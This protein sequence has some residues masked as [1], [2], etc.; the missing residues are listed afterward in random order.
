MKKILF[1][2]MATLS[3]AMQAQTTSDLSFV[4]NPV[5]VSI[6]EGKISGTLCLPN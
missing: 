1:V 2:V 4:E 3:F 5:E 6:K